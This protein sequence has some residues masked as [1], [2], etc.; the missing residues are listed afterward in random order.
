M[1]KIMYQA[2]YC[3]G[4]MGGDSLRAPTPK[5]KYI[6]KFAL[7]KQWNWPKFS[8]LPPKKV[9]GRGAAVAIKNFAW[10]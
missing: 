7:E 4:V 8:K 3:K 2:M 1:I 6:C 10:L 5:F 9:G